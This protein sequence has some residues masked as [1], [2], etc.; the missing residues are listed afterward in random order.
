MANFNHSIDVNVP[1]NAAYNQW[2]QFETFPKFME[3]IEEVRQITETRMLWRAEI[4]GNEQEWEAEITEQIPDKRIAWTSVSGAKHGGVVTFHYIDENTTRV[5]LQIDYEPEGFL[6]NV[7]VALG[8]VEGRMKGDLDRFKAFI[9]SRS[10]AT[11]AW[12]GQVE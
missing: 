12:R 6:E 8:V 10:E 7:G 3:G 2:T 9:E 1:V 4:A 11:G 5:M